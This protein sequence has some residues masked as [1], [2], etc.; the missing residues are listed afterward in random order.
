MGE[1]ITNTTCH[2]WT[3]HTA[4]GLRIECVAHGVVADGVKR[5]QVAEQQEQHR[6][7]QRR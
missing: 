3:H 4:A 5:E 1:P 7:E 6:Q 2:Q